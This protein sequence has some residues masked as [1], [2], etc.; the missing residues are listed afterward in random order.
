[1]IAACTS[2]G[3]AEETEESAGIRIYNSSLVTN[4]LKATYIEG[5]IPVADGQDIVVMH[6]LL[7]IAR[8]TMPETGTVASFRIKI[9]ESELNEKGVT[10]L[11]IKSTEGRTEKESLPA[12]VSITYKAKETQ[13]IST[14]KKEYSLTM[15]GV[16]EPIKAKTSSGSDVYYV[17][18]DPKVVDVD[19]RGNLEPVG[20]GK[21]EIS[22]KSLG[23]SKYKGTEKKV[24]VKVKDI[25]AYKI[26]F[27]SEE[28]SEDGD[29]KE[30]TSEQI[31]NIGE[32]ESLLENTFDN[33]DHSFLGWATE[34][35]G[36]VVYSDTE[37][38]SD[39]GE[40]GDNVD[41]Y[42]VWTGDGAKAA[43]AWAI[44][45]ANDNSFAYGTGAA[46]HRIGCYFCGTNQRNKPK[47]YEKT[48]V[49]LTFVGA[50]YAHGAEDPEILAAD[51]ANKMPMYENDDN[52]SAFS[53]W[54]K[55]GSC[56]NLTIDDLKP[57]DVIIMWAA[58]NDTGHVCM[59][60]GDDKIVE[61]SHEGWGANTISV[62]SGA[63]RRL[64][65]LGSNSKNYVMRYK[66]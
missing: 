25:D 48:Y 38:V 58:N 12:R 37:S 22:I 3:F 54:Y 31:I 53:C 1:M 15:P 57:G 61:A 35:G 28:E 18:S 39:L 21:A 14:S 44:N 62:N 10:A 4:D 47:G 42:A 63:A 60:A 24:S 23:N 34:E 40:K 32:S 16:S 59:Y 50:A 11:R 19:S 45:I 6:G 29:T 30:E 55:V 7:P 36:E 17:S 41:L 66:Y 49:C 64:Q 5:E 8:K 20:K 33:G 13:T 26:T 9:P 51:Q 46:C 43:L 2:F 52:F 27:H 65:R 56:S